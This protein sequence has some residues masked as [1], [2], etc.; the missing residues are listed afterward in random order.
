[1]H[2]VALICHANSTPFILR[3]RFCP[4]SGICLR[5]MH[6]SHWEITGNQAGEHV[7]AQRRDPHLL[8][9]HSRCPQTLTLIFQ[10]SSCH[11]QP[12]Q[13]EHGALPSC[14]TSEISESSICASLA[15]HTHEVDECE[16]ICRHVIRDQEEGHPRSGCCSQVLCECCW[17]T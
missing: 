10:C 12:L 15:W 2:H 13:A 14:S 8:P 11:Q 6:P 7:S 9:Q 17:C 3:G 1:M 4:A 16:H 5:V